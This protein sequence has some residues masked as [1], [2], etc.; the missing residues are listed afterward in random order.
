MPALTRRPESIQPALISPSR[1]SS[2]ITTL[3]AQLG[4]RPIKAERACDKKGTAV[5]AAERVSSP[6]KYIRR[7]KRKTIPKRKP[8]VLSV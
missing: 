3:A 2:V 7:F 4:I 6:I 8:P 5:K 1:Y